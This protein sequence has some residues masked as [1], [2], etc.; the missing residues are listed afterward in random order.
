MQDISVD[1]GAGVVEVLRSGRL[2]AVDEG[3]V[4]ADF[5]F[6]P[7]DAVAGVMVALHEWVR[8]RVTARH[9]AGNS[10]SVTRATLSPR[11]FLDFLRHF[12]NVLN[13]C[14]A[15]HSCCS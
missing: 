5:L 13:R 3:V 2:R 4:S 11:D 1:A 8:L 14:G 9:G 7:R 15:M 10:N 6:S 12:I